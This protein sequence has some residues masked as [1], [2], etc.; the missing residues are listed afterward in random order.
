MNDEYEIQDVDIAAFAS[1]KIGMHSSS[2]LVMHVIK[3]QRNQAPWF[4]LVKDS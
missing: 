4:Q 2:L 3:A 1:E